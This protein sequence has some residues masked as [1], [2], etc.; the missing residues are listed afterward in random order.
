LPSKIVALA[1]ESSCPEVLADQESIATNLDK[2]AHN[3]MFDRRRYVFTI[4]E[5]MIFVADFLMLLGG[6]V[7]DILRRPP[8]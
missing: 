2:T 7:A 3:E 4:Y 6:S 5:N 1:Q 8:A